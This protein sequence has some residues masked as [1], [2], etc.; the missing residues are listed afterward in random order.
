DEGNFYIPVNDF[1]NGDEF[2]LLAKYEGTRPGMKEFRYELLDESVPEIHVDDRPEDRG[3]YVV[4]QDSLGMDKNNYGIDK[5]NLLPEVQVG[6]KSLVANHESSEKY[7]GNNYF[8]AERI[9]EQN[10]TDMHAILQAMPAIQV[11][12]NPFYTNPA[13]RNIT[14]SKYVIRTTRPSGVLGKKDDE[15]ITIVLDGNNVEADEIIHLNVHDISSVQYLKPHE[16]LKEKGVFRAIDGALV[17]K[18]KTAREAA[19]ELKD[20]RGGV[21]SAPVGLSNFGMTY[22]PSLSY[23]DLLEMKGEY[24]LVVD[25]VSK[26]GI[27]SFEWLLRIE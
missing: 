6:A 26:E 24:R 25:L 17:I 7:Y 19:M 13:R 12:Q 21:Y 18:T 8:D 10:Y 1:A 16:A 5:N 14:T 3:W 22:C 20:K 11:A 27:S 2:Y 9:R 15:S 23:S 4:I